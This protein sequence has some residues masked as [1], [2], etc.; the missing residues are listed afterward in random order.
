MLS[1]ATSL[2]D[3]DASLLTRAMEAV[4]HP[5]ASATGSTEPALLRA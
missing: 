2:R 4:E 3:A 1:D 5:V